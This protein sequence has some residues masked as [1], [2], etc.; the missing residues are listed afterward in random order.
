MFVKYGFY[1]RVKVNINDV[2][3]KKKNWKIINENNF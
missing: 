1:N 3:V 2:V